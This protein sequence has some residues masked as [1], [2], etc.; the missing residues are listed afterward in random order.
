MSKT[1][2]LGQ[3]ITALRDARG[4]TRYRLA[5]EAGISAI[6]LARIEDEGRDPSWST[7]C[8][9]ADALGAKLEQFRA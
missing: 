8:K 2:T 7:I 3:R 5:K 4:W 1:A 6:N 9:L